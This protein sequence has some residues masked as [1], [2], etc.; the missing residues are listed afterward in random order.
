[1]KEEKG[2]D[3]ETQLSLSTKEIIDTQ[4]NDAFCCTMLK[5]M[6]DKNMSSNKY[7]VSNNSL[8]H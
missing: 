4:N 5:L 1:M 3:K 2:E 6:N 7:F 8:L